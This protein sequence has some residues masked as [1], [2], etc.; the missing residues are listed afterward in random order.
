MKQERG[1]SLL[2]LL[3]VV[4]IVGVISALAVPGLR[5]ARQNAN[6]AS[7]IQSLRTITTAQ[8][9]Y[10]RQFRVYGTLAQLTPEGT[11]DDNITTGSKS[12]YRFTINLT[13]GAKSFECLAT[14]EESQ[15]VLNHFFVDETGVIRFNPGAPAT[16]ASPP[17][18]R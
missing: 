10:E 16:V 9:L 6:G 11:L 2:E 15:T 7:A 5:R 13:N 14:P 17:I 4:V 8:F 12:G 1:F 18:P 3:M